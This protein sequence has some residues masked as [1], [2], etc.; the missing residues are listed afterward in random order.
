MFILNVK[1][2]QTNSRKFCISKTYFFLSPQV[3]DKHFDRLDYFHPSGGMSGDYE[4]PGGEVRFVHEGEVRLIHDGR[5]IWC[6]VWG[7]IG[8]SKGDG[9]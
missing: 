7:D 3:T 8:V 1:A 5:V 4:F 6:Q 2:I 9:M